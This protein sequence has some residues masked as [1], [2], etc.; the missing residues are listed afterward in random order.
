[1]PLKN[2]I[3]AVSICI[4]IIYLVVL[5]RVKAGISQNL[6]FDEDFKELEVLQ[7]EEFRNRVGAIYDSVYKIPDLKIRKVYLNL[8]FNLTERKD[9]IAHIRSLINKAN[10]SDS[11]YAQLFEK[12]HRL[13]KKRNNIDDICFVEYSRA[14][15]YIARKQF[16]SAMIHILKYKEMTPPSENGEGYR[17]IINMLGDVYYHSGLYN[18]AKDIYTKI[19][20]QY[21]K[22]KNWNHYRAYV[23]MNNLGQIALKFDDI[24][25]ASHW[26][27][28]SLN[29]AE[30]YLHE[31]YR[32]NT[33]AYIRVKLAQTAIQSDN[34]SEAEKQF[35]IIETYPDASIYDDVYQEY[36][37]YKAKLL[38]KQGSLAGAQNIID[39]LM[40]DDSHR[41]FDARF[42]PEIYKLL[43][44]INYQLGNNNKALEYARM[45]SEITDSISYQEHTARSMIILE[46]QKY[47]RT[48]KKLNEGKKRIYILAAGIILLI[49]ILLIIF[50]MYFSLRKTK[51]ALVNS[52]L[53]HASGIET[54]EL[55]SNNNHV[56]NPELE[57]DINK[58]KELVIK[59]KKL[60]ETEKTFLDPKVNLQSLATMLG[61]NRTY[62][63]KAINS[64]L[65]TSFPNFINEYRIR[66][67]IRLITNGYTVS[68][69]QDALARQSG[70]SN[71]NVF[72]AAF[73]KH[74][75][76][77]PSFFISNYKKVG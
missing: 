53:S 67:A 74:T 70:F 30:K 66:E 71:R 26:F 21:E 7:G 68:R 3:Q 34:L 13:A 31:Y 75:G 72:I 50:Y 57:S 14:Q 64:Q 39:T 69:T 43:S 47:E 22:Q 33:I 15:F 5:V 24:Q 9:D 58:Q 2:K 54:T 44:E 17:N 48:L 40:S 20:K 12:A 73:K 1:M 23:M 52:S 62:L 56:T 6:N 11:N 65:N 35:I 45:Y 41:F 63:S 59:L 51:L 10:Y 76:V 49:L 16:D 55:L 60:M 46:N 25:T 8:L 61:S 38:I 36:L 29:R 28:Q 18:E 37:Y 77:L 19:Y 27:N 42:I 32:I 4:F